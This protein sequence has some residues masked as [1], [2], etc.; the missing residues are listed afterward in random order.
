M[1]DHDPAKAVKEVLP[2]WKE[3]LRQ[4][5][6][7][8]PSTAPGTWATALRDYE[9]MADVLRTVIQVGN[10]PGRRGSRPLPDVEVGTEQ[11][12]DL[13]GENY[14]TQPFANAL[15]TL[16]TLKGTHLTDL[17]RRSGISRSKVH[18]LMTGAIEPSGEDME[19]LAA[20]FK[21]SP[22]FWA[23]YRTAFVCA[24]FAEFLSASPEASVGIVR[25]LRAE[26]AR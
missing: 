15:A 14:T 11:L 1:P 13:L 22:V 9:L 23:E 19:R 3:R 16:A 8:Y 10:S 2:P 12:R 6:K 4:V 20:V 24:H 26:Q 18:R 17:A 21:K 5:R 7:Q 25:R